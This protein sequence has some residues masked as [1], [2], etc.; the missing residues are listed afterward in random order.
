MRETNSVVSSKVKPVRYCSVHVTGSHEVKDLHPAMLANSL[1]KDE[2][3]RFGR[4]KK[5]QVALCA[6]D[7]EQADAV[8]IRLDHESS[9]P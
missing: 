7:L 1:A 2:Q 8:R 3:I 5:P 4:S 6:G 9:E